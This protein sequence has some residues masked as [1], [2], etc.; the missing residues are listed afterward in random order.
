MTKK[1]SIVVPVYKVEKYVRPCIESIFNQGLSDDDYE[2][3]V[4][5]DG[6]PDRSM[7]QITDLLEQHSNV[8][9][10]NQENQGVSV[11]RNN[12]LAKATGEYILFFDSDD[13]M[14]EGSLKLMLDKALESQADMV[15][16][17]YVEMNDEE[18]DAMLHP[19]VQSPTSWKES[20]GKWLYF[21]GNG[22]YP[23]ASAVWRTYY[24]MEFLKKHQIIF[25]P[26]VYYEDVD[27]SINA[28]LKA[29]K[30]LKTN[31]IFNIYRHRDDSIMNSAMTKKKV[32]DYQSRLACVW[33]I[34]QNIELNN[35]ERERFEYFYFIYVYEYLT[36]FVFPNFSRYSD[37]IY[38][39]NHLAKEI[40]VLRFGKGLLRQ[41]TA[42]IYNISP[43][44]L[45]TL[46]IVKW[47]MQKVL[48]KRQP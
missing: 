19:I 1:L 40:P 14:I 43:K 11:A 25:S 10:I 36:Y 5:N 48:L 44:L 42:F 31:L 39:I 33:S 37:R 6:T 3:I 13:I 24:R 46:W 28:Y 29:V 9:V 32:E 22:E 45:M 27:F 4:V 15:V 34:A 8:I 26:S 23:M 2:L 21:Y 30:V 18:I 17:E 35:Q 20:T 16:G 38:S 12:G 41:V 47:E 7:E